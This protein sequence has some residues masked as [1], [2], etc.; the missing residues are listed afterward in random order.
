[1]NTKTVPVVPTELRRL[2]SE[3]R[4]YASIEGVA[5]ALDGLANDIEASPTQAGEA[6]YLAKDTG[7]FCNLWMEIPN[8]TEYDRMKSNGVTVRTLYTSA[9]RVGD[10]LMPLIERMNSYLIMSGI[11]GNKDSDNPLEVL[12]YDLLKAIKNER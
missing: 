7:F 1:M 8:K 10:D 3:L 6:V 12:K 11:Q 5:R 2:A 4:G 9:P